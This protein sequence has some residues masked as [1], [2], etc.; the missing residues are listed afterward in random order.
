MNPVNVGAT[1]SPERY[2]KTLQIVLQ[3]PMIDGAL[4]V[5]A[6]SPVTTI[7]PTLKLLAKTAAGSYKPVITAWVSDRIA[8]SVR[9]PLRSVPNAPIS[10]IQSPVAAA[11]AFGYLAA[12]ARRR[13]DRLSIPP[14]WSVELNPEGDRPRP[15][16]QVR[17]RGR[18]ARHQGPRRSRRRMALNGGKHRQ[19]LPDDAHGGRRRAED[20][21]ALVRARASSRH[22]L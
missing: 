13:A 11:L 1:A 15:Q 21:A 16:A 9:K 7:D 5:V 19:Q 8:L 20:G 22:C 17:H 14:E 3:D 12:E 2:R 18:G 10:V 4:V 6:P